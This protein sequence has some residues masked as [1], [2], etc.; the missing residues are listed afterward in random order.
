[1]TTR[2]RAQ[3]SIL[4]T[5]NPKDPGEF[6]GIVR[7]LIPNISVGDVIA[8]QRSMSV[9]P[10]ERDICEF[11]WICMQFEQDPEKWKGAV[12]TSWS[13]VRQIIDVQTLEDAFASL[14]FC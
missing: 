10:C 13:N 2:P 8:W 7:T 9:R 3:W 1:M 6:M 4:K 11:I 14:G 5:Q 12:E